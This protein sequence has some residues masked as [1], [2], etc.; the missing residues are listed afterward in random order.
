MS[1]TSYRALK[2]ISGTIGFSLVLAGAL[3]WL[4]GPASAQNVTIGFGEGA[5]VTERAIQL[6]ALVTVLSL[7]PSILIMVT[8]FTRIVVVLSLLR[9]AI[10]V[11]QSPP[12]TVVI[13]LALF[14]TAFV[15]APVFQKAY[16]AGIEPLMNDKIEV[17][18]AFEKAS[19]PFHGFMLSHVREKDL[20]LFMDMAGG[21]KPAKAEDVSLRVLVPAFMI[22]ELK[23][24]FEIG[25]LLFVPF[26]VIDM[27]V[28]SVLMSM[29]MMML[30]PIIISL[31]F[32]LVFFV[33][34]DGW[35][36]VAGSLV[37]SYGL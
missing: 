37:Q 34:V 3:L 1:R 36:L 15:M 12:N 19:G 24:A 28:A 14:L 20:G 9:T 23:R 32:K 22:S 8:S 7:A 2:T 31:P 30:P 4:A 33:L 18:Q 16:D 35:H 25:F 5:G 10:G 17:S 29:G 21:E 13:S 27:V 6:I 11:Q 26:I